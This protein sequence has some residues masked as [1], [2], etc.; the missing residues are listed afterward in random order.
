MVFLSCNPNIKAIDM[1]RNLKEVNI[2]LSHFKKFQNFY[3]NVK[4][5]D[6]MNK[7]FETLNISEKIEFILFC[8][9]SKGFEYGSLLL[10]PN[11]LSL[12]LEWDYSRIRYHFYNSY[13]KELIEWIYN[14][15]NLNKWN[16]TCW[17]LDID[18][19]MDLNI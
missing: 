14:P 13:G 15:K 1:L 2:N 3:F 6:I 12:L 9:D 5:I 17:D 11:V 8:S 10:N 16:K 7:T 4:N 19:N 18:L